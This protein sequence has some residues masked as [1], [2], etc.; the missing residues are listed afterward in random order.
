M[1]VGRS[2]Q[3]FAIWGRLRVAQLNIGSLLETDWPS[4]ETSFVAWLAH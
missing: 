2:V 4:A 3:S 1:R